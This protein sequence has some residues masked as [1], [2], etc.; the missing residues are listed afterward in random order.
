MIVLLQFK[1][2]YWASAE[3]FM[4]SYPRQ[5]C[6]LMT[7]QVSGKCSYCTSQNNMQRTF[8]GQLQVPILVRMVFIA[9]NRC[10]LTLESSKTEFEKKSTSNFCL[11]EIS[12][13]QIKG[14]NWPYV[15]QLMASFDAGSNPVSSE[16]SWNDSC[17]YS[18]DCLSSRTNLIACMSAS[19]GYLVGLSTKICQK[20]PIFR[21]F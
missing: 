4:K 1:S 12:I 6:K 5:V 15:S 14:P 18:N 21:S 13:Q 11:S 16:I 8:S 2:I 19:Q 7:K 3:Q 20:W 9:K 17:H 10:F